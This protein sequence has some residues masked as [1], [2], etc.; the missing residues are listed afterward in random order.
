MYLAE[1]A[2][3]LAVL[4][5]EGFRLY[6]AVPSRQVRHQLQQGLLLSQR[7][8]VRSHHGKLPVCRWL[9]RAQV[10]MEQRPLARWQLS[11]Y[12]QNLCEVLCAN[13]HT[14][15]KQSR[16]WQCI[17]YIDAK[18]RFTLAVKNLAH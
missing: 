10:W 1:V 4:F 16:Q 18:G 9:Q 17:L 15:G 8:D 12:A 6:P 2:N 13:F 5:P 14:F 3:L 11:Y 7:R